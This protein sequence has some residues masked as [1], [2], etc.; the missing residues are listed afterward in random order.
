MV[1]IIITFI[2]QLNS[3]NCDERLKR[4]TQDQFP[5][6]NQQ[7]V[8]EGDGKKLLRITKIINNGQVKAFVSYL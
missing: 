2:K 5:K 4:I 3:G 8:S 7:V 6:I 1:N